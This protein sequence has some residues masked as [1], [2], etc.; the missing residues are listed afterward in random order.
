M[1]LAILALFLAS[2]A[3]AQ[4]VEIRTMSFNVRMGL[5]VVPNRNWPARRELVFRTIASRRPDLVALQEDLVF[6]A[7]E[8]RESL[9]EVWAGVGRGVYT[10]HVGEFNS[11]LFRTDRFRLVDDG[12]FWLSDTPDR[13]ATYP[14]GYPYPRTVVWCL[15]ECR[16]EG[17]RGRR[18]RVYNTH[19]PHRGD[20]REA[21]ADLIA[22]RI[23]ADQ[24][25]ERTAVVLL[26]DF[27]ASVGTPPID[28]LAGD[29]RLLRDAFRIAADPGPDHGTRHDFTGVPVWDRIDHILVT[30]DVRVDRAEIVEDNEGDLY[31]S[32][33]YPIFARLRLAGD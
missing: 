33:H 18:I 1:R 24:A 5:D 32:D 31:P 9:G 22:R 26:G 13:P 25:G 16:D 20:A 11:I 29:G 27:N 28:R 23:E 2:A 6:Q 15:L 21:C 30:P 19:L 8:I 12:L 10:E 4:D 7:R 3:C 14:K 17:A